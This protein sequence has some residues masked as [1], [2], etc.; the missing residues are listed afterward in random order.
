[1]LQALGFFALLEAA[2]LAA[3][4]LA[5]LVL[6][7]LPGAG[8]GFAKPLG[9]LLVGWLAWMAASLGIA[10]YGRWSIV[11]AFV[12]VA[13]AG[14]LAALR[15]RTLRRTLEERGE[16]SGRFARWRVRR[17]AARALPA[18]DPARRRL[19]IGAEVVFAVTFAAT[20]LL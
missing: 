5:G 18:D 13:V 11:G 17:L 3:A 8:L 19:L 15:Q 9:V 4:P 1:M 10:R 7:R 20:A 16:P 14:L 12:L 6:G 2:G